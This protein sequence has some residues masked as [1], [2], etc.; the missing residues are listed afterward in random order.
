MPPR[1]V[2]VVRQRL[3]VS[4]KIFDAFDLMLREKDGAEFGKIQPF[5]R[6]VLDAAEIEVKCVDVNVGF[7]RRVPKKQGPLPEERPRAL[8]RKQ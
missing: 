6:S 3:D 2:E 8:L 4:G 7:H 1:R 5:I